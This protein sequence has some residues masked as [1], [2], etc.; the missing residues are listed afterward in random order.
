MVSFVILRHFII[1]LILKKNLKRENVTAV[2]FAS[3]LTRVV[4]NTLICKDCVLES[5]ETVKK[6][7]NYIKTNRKFERF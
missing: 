4:L 3:F 2:M 1:L 5:Y 6:L 7:D